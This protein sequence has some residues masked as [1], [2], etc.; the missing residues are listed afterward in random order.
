[1]R[2]LI[3]L[4]G[5][6]VRLTQERLAHILEHPEMAGLEQEIEQTLLQA[7]TVMES[8]A[9]TGARL[10]YRS[11]VD[12]LAGD[13]YLCVVV[14]FTNGDAFVITAYLTDKVKRGRS[15]WPKN[16]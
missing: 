11:I 5:R 12:T 3:D 9:D 8:R 2:E 10:Y 7:E 4:F 16:A 15:L 13:K 14:K 1:M 6:L